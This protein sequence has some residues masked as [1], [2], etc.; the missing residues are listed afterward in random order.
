MT[1]LDGAVSP[2]GAR[3]A[4]LAETSIRQSGPPLYG[5]IDVLRPDRVAGW[6]ID[7]RDPAAHATVEI[8]RD[9]RPIASAPA[10]RRRKDLA[11]SGVGTGAYGFAVTLDPAVD[12]GMEFT[13]TVRAFAPDGAEIF[14]RPSGRLGQPSTEQRVLARLLEEMAV[15]RTLLESRAAEQAALSETLSR[16]EL[17]QAR[18]DSMTPRPEEPDNRAGSPGLWIV[19][20]AALATAG[21]SALLAALSLWT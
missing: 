2:D 20:I 17:V 18:L 12:E 4:T 11:T 5:V 3:T 16:V 8:R 21:I 9:G 14:L 6:V 19:S 1:A 7:R 15:C 13:L 10:N